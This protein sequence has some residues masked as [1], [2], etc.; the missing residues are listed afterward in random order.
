MAGRIETF[1]HTP[2]VSITYD[3]TGGNKN[4]VVTPYLAFPRR[5]KRLKLPA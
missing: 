1:T 2:I 3:G 4:E 5:E